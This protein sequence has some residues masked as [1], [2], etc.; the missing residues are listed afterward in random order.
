[1]NTDSPCPTS[2]DINAVR[3]VLQKE[4]LSFEDYLALL[5]PAASEIIEELALR[6]Q[7]LT[8]KHFGRTILLYA[9]IYVCN[10][11]DNQCVYCGF[12]SKNSGKRIC[13][14]PEEVE[15]EA[16]VLYQKGFRH[17]LLVSGEKK[18]R[19][20]LDYLKE[21]VSSLHAKFDSISLEIAPLEK[22]EYRE[23]FAAGADGLTVYQE[24][25]NPDVYKEMHPRGKKADYGFRLGTP[26]RAGE[27]GF[28]R[29]NIGALLGLGRWEEE[30]AA[31][32]LHAAYLK[33]KFWQS[34]I[35]VSFPRLRSS[36]ASFIP[37][38]PVS[39]KQLV[40]MLCALRIFI[41]TLGLTISTRESAEFRDH[42]IPLGV[43]QMSAESK[44]SPGAYSNTQTTEEQFQVADTRSL[45]EVCKA[46]RDK[47]YDPVFK[48]WDRSYI[49]S[50]GAFV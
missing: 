3:T 37:P 33:K 25:Y 49:P 39:D 6:A 44:T 2:K 28:Y 20:S 13:L 22:E 31:V 26:E 48:D 10:E 14:S 38:H 42:L 11:C 45:S 46:I 35:A 36:S 43:T 16:E 40:Q 17:I 34:Q 18:D 24:V 15:K 1:M 47:G 23:L 4:K 8:L 21:V 41:P 29:I 19:V 5:S 30:A 32:G 12:N 50:A 9:P 27:A 7:A